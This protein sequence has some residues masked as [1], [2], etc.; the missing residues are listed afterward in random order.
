VFKKISDLYVV[1]LIALLSS[2]SSY[3]TGV[4]VFKPVLECENSIEVNRLGVPDPVPEKAEKEAIGAPIVIPLRLGQSI[5]QKL[6]E[7]SEEKNNTTERVEQKAVLTQEQ[8]AVMMDTLRRG[9]PKGGVPPIEFTPRDYPAEPGMLNGTFTIYGRAAAFKNFGNIKTKIRI[10]IRT[11]LNVSSDFKVVERTK[12]MSDKAF[13]E[14]K[15]KNPTASEKNGSHKYRML[16][17]DRDVLKLLRA[18]PEDEDFDQVLAEIKQGALDQK[19][20]VRKVNAML[21]VI[22]TLATLKGQEVGAG[23]VGREFIKAQYATSYS[24]ESL[25]FTEKGYLFSENRRPPPFKRR[26]IF[27]RIQEHFKPRPD[28]IVKAPIDVEYQLT[29][30]NRVIGF[31]PVLKAEDE[32]L[33]VDRYFNG[34]YQGPIAR[35]PAETRTVEMKLPAKLAA[36]RKSF[37][38]KTHKFIQKEFI[39]RMESGIVQ[40][41][42]FNGGKSGHISSAFHLALERKAKHKMISDPTVHRVPGPSEVSE[43]EPEL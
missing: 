30:D 40:G 7:S 28:E 18:N 6:K 13:L 37:R 27:R 22:R 25:S 26:Q 2:T 39:D 5:I 21:E 23:N 14:I 34:E 32:T 8:L 12:K 9:H 1:G 43:P 31:I 20:D 19:N 33:R 29:I 38:S 24:R 17:L 11:Y 35:Y 42:H 10:R 15:I 3:A 16:L 41:F 36:L 4:T